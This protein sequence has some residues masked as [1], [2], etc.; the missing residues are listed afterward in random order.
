MMKARHLGA[1][2]RLVRLEGTAL[3]DHAVGAGGDAEFVDRADDLIHMGGLG[4][5]RVAEVVINGVAVAASDVQLYA[6]RVAID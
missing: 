4:P 3:T 6:G 1:G 5:S 2:H